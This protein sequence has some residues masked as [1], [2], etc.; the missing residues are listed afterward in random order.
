MKRIIIIFLILIIVGSV[1][2]YSIYNDRLMKS[3]SDIFL[4]VLNGY[5][6]DESCN[7]KRIYN[8]L[9]N[10]QRDHFVSED[11]EFCILDNVRDFN[12]M[13]IELKEAYKILEEDPFCVLENVIDINSIPNY[14]KYSDYYSNDNVERDSRIYEKNN[15]YYIKYKDINLVDG[16][17]DLKYD[18]FE[19]YLSKEDVPYETFQKVQSLKPISFIG[20][21]KEGN[22][23]TYKFFN[24]MTN[25]FFV[26]TLEKSIWGVK[27]C[28]IIEEN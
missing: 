18:C 3:Y 19:R 27:S 17:D 12:E 23:W 15:A 25:K 5:N 4:N 11:T 10:Y 8:M 16:F 13:A 20:V 24:S 7:D 2:G 26:I 6:I 21:I 14:K 22:S 28:K 9:L 1:V